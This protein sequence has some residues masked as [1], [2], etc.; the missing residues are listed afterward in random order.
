MCLNQKTESKQTKQQSKQQKTAES[1][2]SKEVNK[3]HGNIQQ[4]SKNKKQIRRRV[5]ALSTT[6]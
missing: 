1:K 6:S 4:K 5:Y 2:R 3:T